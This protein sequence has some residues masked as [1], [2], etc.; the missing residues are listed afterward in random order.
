MISSI[1]TVNPTLNG[2]GRGLSSA[3]RSLQA[4]PDPSLD[5]VRTVGQV[6]GNDAIGVG[7]PQREATRQPVALDDGMNEDLAQEPVAAAVGLIQDKTALR[8]S[9]AVLKTADRMV[10]TLLDVFG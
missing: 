6:G 8:S 4:T 1:S 5:S 10:G 3:V 7:L 2:L 9:I